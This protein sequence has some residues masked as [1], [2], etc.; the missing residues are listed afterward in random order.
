MGVLN[1]NDGFESFD[2]NTREW[3]NK[4]RFRYIIS[5]KSSY[6]RKMLG[7]DDT[8]LPERL[9][10]PYAIHDEF[11]KY[12]TYNSFWTELKE[13]LETVNDTYKMKEYI[14][15]NYIIVPDLTEKEFTDLILK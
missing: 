9:Q 5:D 2:Y 3:Q 4:L 14:M 13:A 6:I 15:D 7:F 10:G 1:I 8:A 11:L 12:V